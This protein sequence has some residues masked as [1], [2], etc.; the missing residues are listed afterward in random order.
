MAQC[1]ATLLVLNNNSSALGVIRLL[2]RA[3]KERFLNPS[4]GLQLKRTTLQESHQPCWDVKLGLVCSS[5]G[6]TAK[7]LSLFF[8]LTCRLLPANGFQNDP[9]SLVA[10]ALMLVITTEYYYCGYF[11]IL[12][13]VGW[14]VSHSDGSWWD[15]VNKSDL[16]RML[17]WSSRPA[18]SALQLSMR[19]HLNLSVNTNVMTDKNN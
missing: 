2:K 1:A 11:L 16:V 14:F 19:K 18:L 3:L 9:N 8:L 15:D 6:W 7:H 12:Q 17:R 4:R 10:Q 5:S 13:L